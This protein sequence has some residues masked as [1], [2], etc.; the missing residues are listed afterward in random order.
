M[1][2]ELSAAQAKVAG[3]LLLKPLRQ[4]GME[5]RLYPSRKGRVDL[6]LSAPLMILLS[7]ILSTTSASHPQ[8]KKRPWGWRIFAISPLKTAG[9][10]RMVPWFLR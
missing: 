7:I 5:S 10:R 4:K 1:A 8:N 9:F 2:A 6:I 3:S